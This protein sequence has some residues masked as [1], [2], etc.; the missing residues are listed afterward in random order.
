MERGPGLLKN[1]SF[2]L[3]FAGMA[4][5][6]LGDACF[7]VALPIW[8]LGSGGSPRLLAGLQSI[9]SVVNIGLAPLAGTVA[10]RSDRRRI[11]L[12]ADLIRA[13][14]LIGLLLL[15]ANGLYALA[16]AVILIELAGLFFSPAYV[17][18]QGAL[19]HPDDLPRALA[20]FQLLS[21]GVAV[22]GPALAGGAIAWLGLKGAI[23]LD[24]LSFLLSAGALCLV[25]LGW[26]VRRS[27]PRV[28]F[29]QDLKAGV[30]ILTTNPAIR[31]VATL[32]VGINFAGAIFG[33][34]L[35]VIAIRDWALSGWQ[36]G[37]FYALNP[38][39]MTLGVLGMAI[40][41]GRVRAKGAASMVGLLL[42]GLSNV[43]MA[44][45][46]NPLPFGA[47][48]FL[49]GFSFG[50]AQILLLTLYR[51]LVPQEQQ[52]R[53]FGLTGALGRLLMPV[54]AG[55][56]GW[57]V[58]WFSPFHLTGATGGLVVLLAVW[59]LLSRSLRHI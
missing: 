19:V 48:L 37:L 30:A 54:G 38:A 41:G 14:A 32:A 12:T 42:M 52:G 55:L 13:G 45:A 2:L 49:G 40:L 27:G 24:G 59:G 1:R 36:L 4:I 44:W 29:W 58:A 23:G 16:G 9:R 7:A 21:Q 18:A 39:G 8:V 25:R 34:L 28:P 35:P 50:I 5:S 20:I 26:E 31:Q 33:I 15:S 46:P 22:V 51:T 3:V 11:M 56:A 17:A 43:A 6:L 53:F 10:D 47:L 57:A